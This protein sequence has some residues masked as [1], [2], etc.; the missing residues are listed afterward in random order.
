MLDFWNKFCII[1]NCDF[2]RLFF[3]ISIFWSNW[4]KVP[5]TVFQLRIELP[6]FPYGNKSV[7]KY[8]KNLNKVNKLFVYFDDTEWFTNLADLLNALKYKQLATNG[9]LSVISVYWQ[10]H[11]RVYYWKMWKK[12]QLLTLT[13][14]R[15][16]TYL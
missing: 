10:D 6:F 16:G 15:R 13:A 12:H 3:Y 2:E 1:I 7:P 5:F 8:E 9:K 11:F 14:W 4:I